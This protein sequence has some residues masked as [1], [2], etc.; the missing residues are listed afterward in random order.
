LQSSTPSR[1]RRSVLAAATILAF[2]AFAAPAR[3]DDGDAASRPPA[4]VIV[5]PT[6]PTPGPIT[7]TN[8]YGKGDETDG[9]GKGDETAVSGGTL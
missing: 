2:A 5:L 4:A 7:G 9:Y 1:L 8:G 3:A 6:T